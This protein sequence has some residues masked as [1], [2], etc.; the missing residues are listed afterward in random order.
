MPNYN[1]LKAK[2]KELA[3]RNWNVKEI[4]D[5]INELSATGIPKKRIDPEYI[6][7]NQD[8]ILER[9]Q[10]RAEEYTFVLKNCAQG[11]ALAI[12]EEFGLGN[13]EVIKSL[14]TFPGIGGTGEMCG[15]VTG[16]IVALGLYFGSDDRLDYEVL[17]STINKTQEFMATY[18]ERMGHLHCIDIIENV[19]L[20]K[21]IN[22]GKSF[23]AMEEFIKEKGFE[24]CSLC[25][26][27]GAH[28][29]TEFIIK[30]LNEE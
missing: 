16:S 28:L 17:N 1:E 8:E 19:V 21:R 29:V 27:M 23:Q 3:Q 20:G 7:Q 10:L 4:E 18:K 12:M 22:P 30:S 26:G 24:K 13:M 9:V 6:L 11:A 2:V 14:T 15:G 25:P 5:R